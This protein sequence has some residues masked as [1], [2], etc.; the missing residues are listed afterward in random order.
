LI[1]L[2]ASGSVR[3][4]FQEDRLNRV[5]KVVTLVFGEALTE[6]D[7]EIYEG[8][9]LPAHGPGAT[10]DRLKGNQKWTFP[11]WHDRLESLFPYTEY[12]LP[13][14]N[15]FW[16]ANQA[17]F[18]RPEEEPPA[19]VIAIPKTQMTPRLIAAEPTCM[20]YVQQAISRSL[21]RHLER[22]TRSKWFVGFTEQWPNQA[23]A[24]IGSADGSLA[25]LDLSE[26]SDRVSNWLV[27]DL[28][29]DFPWFL[30]G[31]QACRSTRAVLPSGEVVTLQ[32][33]ASMGSAMSFPIEA[34]VFAAVVLERVL[35]CDGL[36]IS[37]ASLKRY[38]DMVRVYGDDI[39]A[40]S[41]T[42]ETVI[43][44]LEVFGF[45]VNRAKS[46]WTG[47]FRESCGKEYFRGEDV[48]IVRVRK[49]FP[50]SQR[51]VPE[52][53]SAVSTRN[54]LANAGMWKTAALF[55]DGLERVLNGHYPFVGENSQVLGKHH[56]DGRYDYHGYDKHGTPF[57]RGYVIRPKI[58]E[59]GIDDWSALMKC[60]LS[61]GEETDE[62]HLLRSGRPRVVSMKLVKARPF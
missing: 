59:N 8:T 6:V 19:R 25:T 36:P 3:T 53:E 30:E 44:G 60:L 43:D 28:F 21:V 47:E 48:S 55:D 18:L 58:P 49:S 27:E 1:T 32:K 46:F 56:P 57:V 51:D 37:H 9:L 62:E 52:I 17:K 15:H 39:I 24:Q 12:A 10:A 40:P 5:R 23:L 2:F 4:L 11:T 29:A 20:Q 33:F 31:I 16:R 38:W 50:A 42:A 22:F 45:K 54:Q 61:V 41:H 26:A 35:H 13:G 7:R 34:M 14:H